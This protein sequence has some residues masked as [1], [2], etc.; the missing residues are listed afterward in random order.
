ML[1]LLLALTV[2][3]SNSTFLH[4]DPA[5]DQAIRR[6]M[7]A[8]YALDLPTARHEAEGLQ[9]RFPD[10]PAG[11][12]LMTGT[13][14]WEALADP[15]NKSIENAFYKAQETALKK[16]EN[17]LKLN[18]YPTIEVTADLASAYGSYA[19]FQ[20]T[21]GKSMWSAVR[22][23][24]TAHSY[25][26]KVYQM[27]PNYYD[28]LVGVGAYNYFAGSLPSM[29][30]PLAWLI[31]AHGDSA[32]GL[33]Q[34]RTAIERARYAQTE[35]RIVY[36]TA[37]LEGK[38]YSEALPVL[39]GLMSDYPE[40]FVFYDWAADWHLEQQKPAQAVDYFEALF[41]RQRPRSTT[42]AQ[43][44]LLQEAQMQSGI[45]K[46]AGAR[47]TLARLK[48]TSAMDVLLTKKV[49]ALEKTLRK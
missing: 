40:N 14:W 31:G 16:A 29:V 30:R 20:F 25:A 3:G 28:I 7:Q 49:A 45:K 44:A 19:R 38:Q 43:Y 46:Y 33:Q 8:T 47:Y 26:E 24:L 5:A 9:I 12:L 6:C 35:A 13:Y 48:E 2:A 1:A 4:D 18:K 21:Q 42:M 11:Y 34:I 36:Y 22:A 15:G 41:Q 17:A 10:H 27:D 39:E 23:G 32:L 37:L